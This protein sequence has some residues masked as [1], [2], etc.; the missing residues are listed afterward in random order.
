VRFWISYGIGGIEG[1]ERSGRDVMQSIIN[2]INLSLKCAVLIPNCSKVSP[3]GGELD[4]RPLF[5]STCDFRIDQIER[6]YLF[7]CRIQVELSMMSKA[8]VA[9]LQE[10]AR[11]AQVLAS[12]VS[13]KLLKKI[14]QPWPKPTAV[15]KAIEKS[16]QPC[17]VTTRNE[18]KEKHP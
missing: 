2:T 7:P 12:I 3:K 5:S 13:I 14:T 9:P 1:R 4:G 18:A 11:F 16:Q 15:S 8:F 10:K 6:I 17:H